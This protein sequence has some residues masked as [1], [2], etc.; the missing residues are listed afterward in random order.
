VKKLSG[1]VGA[2]R[3][4]R[5]IPSPSLVGISIYEKLLVCECGGEVFG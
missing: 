3:K 5:G 1:F 2:M 4:A